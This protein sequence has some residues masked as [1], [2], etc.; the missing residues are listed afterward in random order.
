MIQLTPYGSMRDRSNVEQ[1]ASTLPC[2]AVAAHV[3][4]GRF[5]PTDRL[6]VKSIWLYVGHVRFDDGSEWMLGNTDEED[7]LQERLSKTP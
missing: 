5:K 6:A 2:E 4:V 7:A 3:F 1:A